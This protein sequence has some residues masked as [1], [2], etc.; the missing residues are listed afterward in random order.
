MP[1]AVRRAPTSRATSPTC[2]CSCRCCRSTSRCASSASARTCS[3][4]TAATRAPSILMHDTHGEIRLEADLVFAAA[5]VAAPKVA[6]FA[7]T[8]GFEGAEFLAG[9]PGTVGGALAMNAG[10]YGGE[11]WDYVDPRRHHRSRGAAARAQARRLRARLSPLRPEGHH[12]NDPAAEVPGH[13][14]RG[15]VHRRLVPLPARR[16]R[17]G[18][19]ADQGAPRRAGSPPSRSTCRTPARCSAT[20]RASTPRA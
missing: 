20:R 14:R 15:V 13:P 9:V 18:P 11:T 3:S 8:H 16:R 7:A 2:R 6:R 5:G 10:C 12:G 1:A 19:R 17:E 4:A